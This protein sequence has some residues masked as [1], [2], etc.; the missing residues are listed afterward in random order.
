MVHAHPDARLIAVG[1]TVDGVP[2]D[3]ERSD[4]ELSDAE[5]EAEALAADPDAP[6][7]D[8]AVPWLPAATCSAGMGGW[9]MAPAGLSAAAAPGWRR[10][11][12]IGLV[13]A[14]ALINAAGLCITSGVVTFG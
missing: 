10:R 11:V 4:A 1:S 7:P 3:A 6:L 8:D 14:I 2:S 12:A 13:V 9:Y 5:L